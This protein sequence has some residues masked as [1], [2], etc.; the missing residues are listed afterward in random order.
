MLRIPSLLR[1]GILIVT[2]Y[3]FKFA[4]KLMFI[5]LIV[6]NQLPMKKLLLFQFVILIFFAF[7]CQDDNEIQKS[8]SLEKL[9]GYVQK[10]PYLNGTAI[11]ISELSSELE[12]TGKNFISQILD[13][14]GTFEI[15]NIDLSSQYV[16]L[17]ADGF[18]F[19]EI[20]NVSSTAQ[21]TLFA[22]S[23]LT[24]KTSA[25]A[26]FPAMRNT[27]VAP[28]LPDPVVRGSAKLNAL[29]TMI[30]LDKEPTT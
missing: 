13:N 6:F 24:N 1:D 23:D 15:K 21:L 10:G 17:K 11:T 12:P 25:A 7:A 2:K 5:L 29:Q 14:K 9:S 26:C 3:N 8:L 28:G 22:L 16:E 4:Y 18:Y 27:L 19:N 20:S 30:A